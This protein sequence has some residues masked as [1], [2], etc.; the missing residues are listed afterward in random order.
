MDSNLSNY[1]RL[2]IKKQSS[3]GLETAHP[4]YKLGATTRIDTRPHA[5]MGARQILNFEHFSRNLIAIVMK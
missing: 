5:G 1:G 4:K 2:S 3:T